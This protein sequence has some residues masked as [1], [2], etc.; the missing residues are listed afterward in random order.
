MGDLRLISSAYPGKCRVCKTPHAKYAPVWWRKGEKGV[1][2]GACKPQEGAKSPV[3]TP[4][5]QSPV[6]A[7]SG[8]PVGKDDGRKMV[9]NRTVR[10]FGSWTEFVEYGEL[11]ADPYGLSHQTDQ[12]LEWHGTGS[13]AEAVTL[14]KRGWS[15]IRPEV[16]ALVD[17]IDSVIAPALVPA[18][19]N[20][21]DVSG[22]M[23]DVG[24]YLNGEPE[25]MIETMLSPV[26]KPGRVVTILIDG[27]YSGGVNSGDI[28]ERG[29]AIVAL[30]D[31]L[32][33]MQHNTEIWWETSFD[34]KGNLTYLV[35]LKGAED[36]LD[37]DA[38]MFAIAHPSAH[39]RI[40]C[41][42]QERKGENREF[43]VGKGNSW[44]YPAGL[45]MGEYVGAAIQLPRLEWGSDTVKG[46]VWIKKVLAQFGLIEEEA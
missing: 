6:P 16:N 30:I 42:A 9:G 8:P 20:Y 40:D 10:E 45:Q 4:S 43:A 37:I 11:H 44:G 12:G 7:R 27:F 35:K 33:K 5:P 23:V 26:A 13:Y 29:V 21:F 24:R 15:A 46:A 39:R 38:L 22:G 41:A 32:E 18:F 14:A 17:Q 36:S 31:A 3:A 28:K 1:V 25:C 34:G 19:V 2:C